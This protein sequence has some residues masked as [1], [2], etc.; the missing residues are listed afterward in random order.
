MAGKWQW[1]FNV[2]ADHCDIGEGRGNLLHLLG[3]G[4]LEQDLFGRECSG[5]MHA[6]KIGT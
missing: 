4:L 2:A 1:T 6:R 5:R 3:A